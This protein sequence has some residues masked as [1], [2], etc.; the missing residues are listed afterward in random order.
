MAT[1]G[2]RCGDYEREKKKRENSEIYVN[3]LGVHWEFL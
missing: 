2:L 3:P 1:Q